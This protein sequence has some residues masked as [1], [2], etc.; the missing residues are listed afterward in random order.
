MKDKTDKERLLEKIELLRKRKR[1]EA[2]REFNKKDAYLSE[3]LKP[4]KQE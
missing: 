2:H 1:E 4:K 3:A